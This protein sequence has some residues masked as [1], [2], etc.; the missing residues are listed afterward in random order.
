MMKTIERQ[1]F[2]WNLFQSDTNKL[3]F[4]IFN[5]C[6]AEKFARFHAYGFT[7]QSKQ[8][9]GINLLPLYTMTKQMQLGIHARCSHELDIRYMFFW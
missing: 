2:Q 1:K 7:H 8:N 3:A 9:D 6:D 4:G 5:T